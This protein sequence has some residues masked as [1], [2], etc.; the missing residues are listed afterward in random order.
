MSQKFKIDIP[1]ETKP[2]RLKELVNQS[3]M[4]DVWIRDTPFGPVTDSLTIA[5]KFDL[6]HHNV[7]RAISKVYSELSENR[8]FQ[9]EQNFIENY[10]KA[11]PKGREKKT[12]KV[13]ITEFGLILLL[14]YLNS[15]KARQISAEILYRFFVLKS[16]VKG[17]SQ[18]Q[19]GALKGYYRQQMK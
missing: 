1:F 8:K 12:R 16:Y 4:G 9:I 6:S 18:A 19:I 10:Y 7:L 14:L 17:L 15:P 13:D 2:P 5:I 11:G 3:L